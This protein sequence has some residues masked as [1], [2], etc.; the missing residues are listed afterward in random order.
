MLNHRCGSGHADA[1]AMLAERVFRVFFSH[2]EQ[3]GAEHRLKERICFAV[4]LQ[5]K[6][7]RVSC[8]HLH[9]SFR[10][11]SVS[12]GITGA[13]PLFPDVLFDESEVFFIN[14]QIDGKIC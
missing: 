5:G 4:L 12:K 10:D 14:L 1:G 2:F 6:T 7:E 13:Y 3:E 9:H 8:A 11:S